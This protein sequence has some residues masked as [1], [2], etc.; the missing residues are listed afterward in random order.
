MNRRKALIRSATEE[1][2]QDRAAAEELKKMSY[3]GRLPNIPWREQNIPSAG[4]HYYMT[5]E[6]F[7]KSLVR[8]V[9][10]N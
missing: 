2:K 7:L 6:T 5:P 1:L 9:S 8:V 4:Y 3:D 10:R